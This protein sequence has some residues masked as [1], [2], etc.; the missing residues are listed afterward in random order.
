MPKIFISHASEDKDGF[1]RPLTAALIERKLSVWYDEKDLRPGDSILAKIDDGLKRSDYAIVVFSPAFF[2]KKWTTAE[3]DG[4]VALEMANRKV[5]LPVWYNL[6][7]EQMLNFSPI[8]AGRIGYNASKGIPALV[9]LL[10]HAIGTAE[11]LKEISA[12]DPLKA[13]IRTLVSNVA[14]DQYHASRS[15][16]IDGVNEMTN[17][18]LEIVDGLKA[19]FET[20]NAEDK[21]PSF[22]VKFFTRSSMRVVGP[23]AVTLDTI[24][25][26]TSINLADNACLTIK[27]GI[28]TRD[29]P[30]P[31][32][33]EL[34]ESTFQ[35]RF[36]AD[37][38]VRWIDSTGKELSSPEQVVAKAVTR[39]CAL[40]ETER[41]ERQEEIRTRARD[42]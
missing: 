13:A 40:I 1:V 35:P 42:T 20:S 34:E 27:Y 36:V 11:R 3:L 12:V 37:A 2:S 14:A 39:F 30:D 25:N 16:S 26:S 19:T 23:C 21:Q 32:H 38:G 6:T 22:R 31:G 24:F 9:D 41:A 10:E 29:F 15:H 18:A 28:N 5:I 17:S 8:F 7:V 4:L 33:T